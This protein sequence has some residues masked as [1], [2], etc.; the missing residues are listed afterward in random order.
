MFGYSFSRYDDTYDDLGAGMIEPDNVLYN[1]LNRRKVDFQDEKN[2]YVE[3]DEGEGDKSKPAN[4]AFCED[5]A[6]VRARYERKRAEAQSRRGGGGRQH[7][8]HHPVQPAAPAPR[9]VVGKYIYI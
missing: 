7:Q 2:D 4:D 5:P 1:P 8:T 9:D 6:I 3:E